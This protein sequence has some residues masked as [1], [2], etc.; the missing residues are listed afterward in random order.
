MCRAKVVRPSLHGPDPL[1][2]LIKEQFRDAYLS[3]KFLELVRLQLRL[4]KLVG[5][6]GRFI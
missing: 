1:E 4:L 3:S 6:F 5:N 2:I